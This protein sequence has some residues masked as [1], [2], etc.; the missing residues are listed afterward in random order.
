MVDIG[1]YICCAISQQ[2]T[3]HGDIHKGILHIQDPTSE[4]N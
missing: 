3:L 2:F 1:S 4:P